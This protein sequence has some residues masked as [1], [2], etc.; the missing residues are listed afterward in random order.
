MVH[1]LVRILLR[2]ISLTIE[3]HYLHYFYN[4]TLADSRLPT[5]LIYIYYIILLDST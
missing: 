4:P 3:I 2:C 5:Q 1:E